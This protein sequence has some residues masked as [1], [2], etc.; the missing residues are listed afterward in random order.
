MKISYAI[1]VVNE[2]KEI[3][4][5][6]PLLIEN[7]REVDEIVVQYDNQK[8]TV[9]VLEYLNDLTFDKKIDKTIGYPL[10]GDFG[11]YKQ[12]LTQ[13]CTGDWIFQLDADETI[14]PILIQGLSNILEGNDTIE[15]FFIPRI[16]IVNGLTESHIQKWRWNVNEKGWV[17]FPDV[18]GRLYQNK[19]SIFWAGK[20]HEQLQG[21]ESYTIFPQ[22]ETYCIK[23]IKEIERQEKQNALYETL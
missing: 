22:D 8:V 6:L 5:L 7:K 4:T 18:Q 16:N 1:T 21:F 9:E 11:T 15:M 17:N 10:N 2:I 19:Q 23:H 3:Q 14:D 20:V 13:N 12:H